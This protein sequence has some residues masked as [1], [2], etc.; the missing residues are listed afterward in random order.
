M[1]NSISSFFYRF[2]R[3]FV[4]FYY[5]MKFNFKILNKE[6]IP[7]LKGGYII[8]CNHQKY[9]DPPAIAAMIKGHFSFMAKE[10]LFKGNPFFVLLIKACGAFPVAR[11]SGDN[12]AIERSVYDIKRNRIFVIFPEGHRSKDGK[13]GKAK[14]GVALIAGMANAPILPVCLMY[15]LG[16]TKGKKKN[17]DFAVGELIPAE[18]VCMNIDPNNPE[19]FDRKELKRVSSRIINSITQLQTQILSERGVEIQ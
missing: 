10:E 6:N 9:H 3:Y 14:S 19:A 13:I 11:G 5:N 17:I 12:K 15:D 4:Q 8:A 16:E 1:R 18:E 2:L 7:K